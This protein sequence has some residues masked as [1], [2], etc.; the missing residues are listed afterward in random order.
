MNRS[1]IALQFFST[2]PREFAAQF[3]SLSIQ[4][5][6]LKFFHEITLTYL[7]TS[8]NSRCWSVKHL[9]YNSAGACTGRDVADFAAKQTANGL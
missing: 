4:A 3:A 6:L 8:Q 9:A 7:I 1:P 2:S 5:S